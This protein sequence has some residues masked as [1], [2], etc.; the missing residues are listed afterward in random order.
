[1]ST[2]RTQLMATAA[3]VLS[4]NPNP[5]GETADVVVEVA[6]PEH[7]HADILR[8]TSARDGQERSWTHVHRCS[9]EERASLYTLGDDGKPL[10]YNAISRQEFW[11]V[12]T[13]V[14]LFGPNTGSCRRPLNPFE[15]GD[16][17]TEISQ[18]AR[19]YQGKCYEEMGPF[20]RMLHFSDRVIAVADQSVYEFWNNHP[21]SCTIREL[22]VHVRGED[23]VRRQPILSRTIEL[24]ED[25][26]KR[27]GI[28]TKEAENAHFHVTLHNSVKALET[29]VH[30]T[31]R[32]DG[33]ENWV[34][35][36][37]V[38]ADPDNED[39]HYYGDSLFLPNRDDLSIVIPVDE[40]GV[41]IRFD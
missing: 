20:E 32:R 22:E 7:G 17:E 8:G 36:D 6:Y 5:D 35:Q 14:E 23:V 2:A 33:P 21:S 25:A 4:F 16:L 26:I 41:V 39:E 9:P 38:A 37:V 29:M 18:A 15:G 34:I 11:S 40:G 27:S 1:M 19:G 12:M 3:T 28:T 30:V 13:G 10:I 31:I 24:F